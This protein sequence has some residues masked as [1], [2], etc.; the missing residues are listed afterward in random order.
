M[1]SNDFQ[2]SVNRARSKFERDLVSAGYVKVTSDDEQ[3]LQILRACQPQDGRSYLDIGTGRGYV[4]FALAKSCPQAEVVGIDIVPSVLAGNSR[5]AQEQGL[6]RLTFVEHDGRLLPFEDARFDGIVA[7]YCFH[8]FPDPKTSVAEM[9]RVLKGG[10]FCLICDPVPY[11][12]DSTDYAN[13]F[14]ALRNDG[15]IRYYDDAEMRS[16]LALQGMGWQMTFDTEVKIPRRMDES[17]KALFG[18][19]AR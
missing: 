1:Q 16:M 12:E 7:R 11:D 13:Q 3:L 14:S 18:G 8:H 10:G 17:Y 15:H 2:E 9:G 5:Q 19:N 4:A 6:Y